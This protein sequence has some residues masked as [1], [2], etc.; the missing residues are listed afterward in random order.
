MI[1]PI[2]SHQEHWRYCNV[3]A[4]E[5]KPYPNGWQNNPLTLD[6]VESTN[7]GLLL[8]PAGRGVCAID[9]DGPTAWDWIQSQGI[10]QFPVTPTW[11]SGKPDRCQMAFI[12]YP[13]LWGDLFTKKISTKAPSAPGVRDGEG[14]EFRW[15]GG[16]SVIPP[17]IH[18]GTGRP[19][20]WIHDATVP[21]APLPDDLYWLWRRQIEKIEPK[22]EDT[23]PEVRLDDLG[24]F[25]INE[26]ESLLK[27]L[28]SQRNTL[29]YDTW[30]QVCWGIAHHVGRDAA[31]VL[32][33]M[34]YPEQKSGEYKMVFK[35]WNK[36]RSPTLGSVM[37]LAGMKGKM[38]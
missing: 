13:S 4:G 3:R 1:D 15:A 2:L 25:E 26:A 31:N 7:I 17:S 11:T 30:R 29:D 12:V 20:E 27:I 18:P 37:Y 32:M 34:Y 16:Q 33:K 28:K 38:L 10:R 24:Q 22:A 35:G 36:S 23:E 6:Q 8:G 5:K 19:Y 14:F 9:F 21:T